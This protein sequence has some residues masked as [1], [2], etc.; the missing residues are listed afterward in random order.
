VTRLR[1]RCFVRGG[2]WRIG[3]GK[4]AMEGFGTLSRT[5]LY[6]RVDLR[7]S[8]TCSGIFRFGRV[9]GRTHVGSGLIPLHGEFFKGI[10]Q[11]RIF[12]LQGILAVGCR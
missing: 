1:I 8:C 5:I 3:L 9:R 10:G 12:E 4:F 6:R 11:L 7:Y 2:D